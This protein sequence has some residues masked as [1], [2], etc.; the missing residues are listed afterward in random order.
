MTAVKGIVAESVRKLPVA[1]RLLLAA[2]GVTPHAR[3]EAGHRARGAGGPAGAVAPRPADVQ[4]VSDQCLRVLVP[5]RTVGWWCRPQAGT[6][7]SARNRWPGVETPG[8]RAPPS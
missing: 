4:A 8:R 5:M 1:S 3:A 2:Y 6:A 7:D